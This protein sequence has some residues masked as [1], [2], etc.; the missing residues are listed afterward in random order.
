MPRS[1]PGNTS[2]PWYAQVLNWGYPRLLGD[3]MDVIND[4][5]KKGGANAKSNCFIE[6]YDR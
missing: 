3:K 1:E 4:K 2:P 6:G 5:Y